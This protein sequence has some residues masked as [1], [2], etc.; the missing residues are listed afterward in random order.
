[1]D[2]RVITAVFAP[3]TAGLLI[4]LSQRAPR[5][6]LTYIAAAAAFAASAAIVPDLSRGAAPAAALLRLGPELRIALRVDA[7]GLTFGL[8]ASGLFL[9]SAFY[10]SGYARATKLAAERRYF[11][12]FAI[13]V[14]AALGVAF[15]ADLFTLF[16][17]YEV[18]TFSTFPLVTHTETEEAIRAGRR[19]LAYT[20]SGGLAV[21]A[22]IAWTYR[23]TGSLAFVAGGLVGGRM[24]DSSAPVLFGLFI[25]GFAVKAAIMP[26]HGWLPA[27]MVAPT[28]VSA[29][30]HAVAVVKAGVF[31]CLRVI[32]FVFGPEVLERTGAGGA[33][34]IACMV[35]IVAASLVALQEDNLKRRLAYSTIAQL[36]Y[37]VLGAALL[38]P[39]GMTGA[40]LHLANHGVAKITL[41][42]C[43]G[44]LYVAAG[45]TR[46]SELRGLGRRMPWTFAAFALGSLSLI[47]QPFL[48]GLTG[49]LF[50]ARG[51]LEAS[52]LRAFAVLIGGSLLT[53]AYLLP[54]LKTAFFDPLDGEPERRATPL[55]LAGPP[56]ATA[57]LAVVFGAWPA[58][59]Q[60][61]HDLAARA[62]AAVFGASR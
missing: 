48:C 38:S 32:G 45:V 62:A 1:M 8:L 31:G 61:Q 50:L 52:D 54:V 7:I 21:L 26:L 17:F 44:A 47:G 36:S 9:V 37:I 15:A 30:L 24:A 28:P 33:L 20:V 60:V 13:A 43:A 56:V 27:A 41:F 2:V 19:Y 57:L 3:L 42:F 23:A 53:A 12:C 29:L 14:G 35:T 18:L 40:I 49:K 55:L 58:A 4:A 5:R 22:G 11:A 25:A 16:M 59:I 6:L 51:A 46:V 10:S 34:S 39:Q